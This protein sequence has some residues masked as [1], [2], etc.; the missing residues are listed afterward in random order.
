MA[1]A[2]FFTSMVRTST[3]LWNTM[4]STTL[5]ESKRLL[6]D[7]DPRGVGGE[8]IPLG[9]HQS[10]L[11][12]RR[13]HTYSSTTLL[14]H[15]APLQEATRTRSQHTAKKPLPRDVNPTSQKNSAHRKIRLP[16]TRFLW[17][18]QAAIIPPSSW[19]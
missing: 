14:G 9:R 12:S 10:L 5:R 2:A 13:R 11:D 15:L 4:S 3:V 7:D 16:T 18:L 19:F 17:A 6:C 1:A 8:D